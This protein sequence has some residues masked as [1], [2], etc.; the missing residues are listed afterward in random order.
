MRTW[1]VFRA[2]LPRIYYYRKHFWLRIKCLKPQSLSHLFVNRIN[3]CCSILLNMKCSQCEHKIIRHW[4][5]CTILPSP[6]HPHQNK[7]ERMERKGKHFVF[8]AKFEPLPFL[9]PCWSLV[10]GPYVSCI[11]IR[12]PHAS[13]EDGFSTLSQA[14]HWTLT[15][16]VSPNPTIKTSV[17]TGEADELACQPLLRLKYLLSASG[18]PGVERAGLE[19]QINTSTL[20]LLSEIDELPQLQASSYWVFRSGYLPELSQWM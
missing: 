17:F 13:L 16:C 11:P 18:Y 6:I 14:H 4:D 10:F 9:C 8:S 19:L 7:V 3:E 5:L 15:T 12:N 20:F 1:W 2:A